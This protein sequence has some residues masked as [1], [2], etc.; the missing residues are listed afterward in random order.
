MAQT[1]LRR[2]PTCCR[3]TDT[4]LLKRIVLSTIGISV[5]ATCTALAMLFRP[6]D[7]RCSHSGLVPKS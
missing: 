3:F 6:Y 1:A 2:I 5:K 7:L 4:G